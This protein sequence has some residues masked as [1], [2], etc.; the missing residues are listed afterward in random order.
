MRLLSTNGAPPCASQSRLLELEDE[1]GI[2]G[3]QKAAW[4]VFVE[5]LETVAKT[6]ETI[7][8]DCAQSIHDRAPSLPLVLGIQTQRLTARLQANRL[9]KAITDSLYRSLNPRQ[10]ERADRLLAPI[11]KDIGSAD[12]SA[13]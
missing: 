10:R 9:L 7:D 13:R 2:M 8:A 1:L 5:A 6:L 11:L 4:Q 3:F 12:L